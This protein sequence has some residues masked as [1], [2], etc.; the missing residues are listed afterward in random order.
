MAKMAVLPFI[1]RQTSD[2]V[3]RNLTMDAQELAEGEV[4]QRQIS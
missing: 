2:K 1:W 4:G 3:L